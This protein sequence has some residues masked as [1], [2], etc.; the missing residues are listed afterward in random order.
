MTKTGVRQI[1]SPKA[2]LSGLIQYVSEAENSGERAVRA[3]AAGSAF[4]EWFGMLRAR[5]GYCE[6]L[7]GWS[8]THN[9]QVGCCS[10]ARSGD[11]PTGRLK[12]NLGLPR[13]P[14][15]RSRPSPRSRGNPGHEPR[16]QH[17]EGCGS[18]L[19]PRREHG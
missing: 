7:G 2:G 19:A 1:P 11:W 6:M 18:L 16:G 12:R 10:F 15:R 9:W 4:R 8:R 5:Q 3:E 14:G 13:K 17:G